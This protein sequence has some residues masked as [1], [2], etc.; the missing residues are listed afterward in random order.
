MSVAAKKASA[1]EGVTPVL[2][3]RQGQSVESC[4]IT[5]WAKKVGDPV[6]VGDVIFSYETDKSSFDEEAKVEGVMQGIFFDEGDDVPCLTVVCCIGKAGVDVSDFDPKNAGSAPVA[7]AVAEAPVAAAAATVATEAKKD[8][9]R[10]FISPRAKNLAE[11]L[12]LDYTLASATG[13]YGRIVEK[14]IN[15]L[16]DNYAEIKAAAAP[17]PAVDIKT[18]PVEAKV[19]AKAETV[20]DYKDEPLSNIRKT[21][22]KAMTASLTQMAQL[23]LNSSF[24]ATNIMAFRKK[25]KAAAPEG[26]GNITITDIILYAVSR[27]L[28]NHP[29]VNANL[30]DGKTMRFFNV[31][32]VGLAVDTPRG[33]LVPTIFKADKLSL[34]EISKK[35]KEGA[36][37]CKEGKISPDA[38]KGASFTVSNLGTFG[39]ETFTPVINPPQTCILGVNTIQQKIKIV[40]GEMKPYP[41]MGLSLTFDHRSLD[42]APAARFLKEL[43]YNLENIEVLLIK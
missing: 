27:T 29:Y 6:A 23:T 11:K 9:D 4:V 17:T 18:V 34:A 35:A 1:K 33:L 43:V 21:I 25:I 8:G 12:G 41:A 2:M 15:T 22:S 16:A 31:A 26:V 30:L 3:P 19:E 40:D 13:P 42:G 39:V 10:I 38:L 5:S 28:L 7:E 37:A 14:D 32:N 24:D 36:E 20:A